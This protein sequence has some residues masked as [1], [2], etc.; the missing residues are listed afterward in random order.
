MKKNH[1]VQYLGNET[2]NNEIEKKLHKK[3]QNRKYQLKETG[4]KSK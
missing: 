4:L 1:K 3:F 2:L